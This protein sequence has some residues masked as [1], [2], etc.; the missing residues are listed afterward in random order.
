M[1]DIQGNAQSIEGAIA[2]D[3]PVAENPLL[4][5]GEALQSKNGYLQLSE[6]EKQQLN[7]FLESL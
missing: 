6:K 2:H 1:A 4:H 3:S 7:K 5:G